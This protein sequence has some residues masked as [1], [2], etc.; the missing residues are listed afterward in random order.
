MTGRERVKESKKSA[1]AKGPNRQEGE[2][3]P[4]ITDDLGKGVV[5]EI[6]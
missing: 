6:Q 5:K 3:K 1:S 4:S 2:K